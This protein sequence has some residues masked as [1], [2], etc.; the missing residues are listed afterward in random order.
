MSTEQLSRALHVVRCRRNTFIGMTW[1]TYIPRLLAVANAAVIVVLAGGC[2]GDESPV[3]AGETPTAAVTEKTEAP[4][5]PEVV[6]AAPQPD[7]VAATLDSTVTVRGSNLFGSKSATIE[8]TLGQ[9]EVITQVKLPTGA[10]QRPDRGAFVVFEVVLEGVDG[11]YEFNPGHFHL[12]PRD[13]VPT[14]RSEAVL[15][16]GDR[17]DKPTQIDALDSISFGPISPG[18]RISGNLVFDQPR[19]ATNDAAIVL[20]SL[21]QTDGPPAAYWPLQ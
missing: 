9:P 21:L 13:Q 11:T 20:R 1:Q 10:V 3:G 15:G 12:I 8:V 2:G 17:P 19:T 16:I 7:P 14:W 6:S 5:L 4:R 18:D